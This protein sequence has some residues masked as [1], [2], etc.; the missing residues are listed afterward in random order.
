MGKVGDILYVGG[1]LSS[2]LIFILFIFGY[3]LWIVNTKDI[4]LGFVLSVL[5]LFSFF[6]YIMQIYSLL[7]RKNLI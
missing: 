2:L 4:V 7:K 5:I 1:V 3:L 6:F